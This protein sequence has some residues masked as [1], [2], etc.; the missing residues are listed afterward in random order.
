[1][2]KFITLYKK[3][4]GG[5]KR[6]ILFNIFITAFLL[7]ANNASAQGTL[8]GDGSPS[9][10]YKISSAADWDR[11]TEIIDGTNGAIPKMI[12]TA[13]MIHGMNV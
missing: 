3:T 10:P 11:F 2:K 12:I 1:M 4:T 8:I 9:N 7:F 5:V 6:Y 13:P